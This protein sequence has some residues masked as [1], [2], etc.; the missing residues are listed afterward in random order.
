MREHAN[1]LKAH[2]NAHFFCV[3]YTVLLYC[4]PRFSVVRVLGGGSDGTAQELLEAYHIRITGQACVSQ[5]PVLL[6]DAKKNCWV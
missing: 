1:N 2:M 3:L 4:K 6:Y 5:T